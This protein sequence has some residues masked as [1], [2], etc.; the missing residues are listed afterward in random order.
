MK[1]NIRKNNKNIQG[2]GMI[3]SLLLIILLVCAGFITVKLFPSYMEYHRVQDI[4]KHLQKMPEIQQKTDDEIRSYL[5]KQFSA[6]NISAV[7]ANNNIKITRSSS[8]KVENIIVD[9]QAKKHIV[10]NADVLLNFNTSV[11]VE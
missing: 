10:A 5:T 8:N 2:Q 1:N 9:F 7:D 3:G 4:L 11:K 6:Q